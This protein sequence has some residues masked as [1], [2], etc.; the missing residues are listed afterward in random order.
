[1]ATLV[2]GLIITVLV[3]GIAVAGFLVVDRWVPAATRR[4]HNEVA[5]YTYAF[6]GPLYAILLAFIV[7]TVWGYYDAARL[8]AGDEATALL[9]TYNIALGLG[10]DYAGQIQQLSA[11]YGQSVISDEWPGLGKGQQ[12]NPKTAAAYRALDTAVEA[13]SP[14]DER[15]TALYEAEVTS[16][17]ELAGA[18]SQHL[19]R[20]QDSLHQACGS[21]CTLEQ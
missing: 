1:L 21:L 12:G 11:S 20:G 10:S 16:L 17:N 2:V 15:T 9:K 3:S 14:S 6:I 18:R 8:A 7:V 19:L 4:G 5:G 13:Y